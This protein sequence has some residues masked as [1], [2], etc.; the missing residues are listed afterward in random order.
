[1]NEIS[2]EQSSNR[3]GLALQRTVSV[4]Y[5]PV[6]TF[7]G[8]AR[9][10]SWADWAVPILVGIVLGLVLTQ[11]SFPYLDVET[12]VRSQLEAQGLPAEQIEQLVA[13]NLWFWETFWIPMVVI[14]PIGFLLLLTLPFWG[15]TFLFGGR[16]RFGTTLSVLAYAF[17]AKTVEGILRV[18]AIWGGEPVR[19][20]RLD[21]VLPASP[22]A[23][24]SIEFIDTP[25]FGLLRTLNIFT[26][27]AMALTAIG[28]S[29]TGRLSPGAAYGLV[30]LL[31][32]LYVVI[33][34]GWAAI[35]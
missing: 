33:T 7:Q 21:L 10:S 22:A 20:D 8:L 9:S 31:F 34:V 26:L 13:G 29:E 11:I 14:I 19:Q 2:S 4:F 6:A 17:L 3:W 15:S 5:A 18:A 27:W 35:F 1:V 24:L 16:V 28:L 25:L 12:P 23:L 32:G 30:G